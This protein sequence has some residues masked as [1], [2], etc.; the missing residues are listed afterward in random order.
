MTPNGRWMVHSFSRK[1]CLCTAIRVHG[2]EGCH[3][4]GGHV[5]SCRFIQLETHTGG[6]EASGTASPIPLYNR[7]C[8]RTNINRKKIQK[9]LFRFNHILNIQIFLKK[10]Q[11]TKPYELRWAIPRHNACHFF[12]QRSYDIHGPLW[13]IFF[14]QRI[15]ARL[16]HQ[17]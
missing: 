6:A 12:C 16:A 9:I 11:H 13:P 1:Q 14:R 15:S 3:Q 17:P 4:T 5:A 10:Q 7:K 8:Y 2:K